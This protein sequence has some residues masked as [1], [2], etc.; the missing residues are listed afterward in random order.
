M[1]KILYSIMIATTICGCSTNDDIIQ[2]KPVGIEGTWALIGSFDDDGYLSWHDEVFNYLVIDKTSIENYYYEG[3]FEFEYI[4]GILYGDDFESFEKISTAKYNLTDD[5]YRILEHDAGSLV[6]WDTVLDK[7]G[8]Y[9][10]LKDDRL[11][12]TNEDCDG[13]GGD[14]YYVTWEYMRVDK[15]ENK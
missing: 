14:E 7:L 3:D 1:K 15:F 9:M 5:I 13:I 2:E 11:I 8:F 10:Q 6:V 12:V 4:D